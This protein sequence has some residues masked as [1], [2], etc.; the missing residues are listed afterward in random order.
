MLFRLDIKKG[1]ENYSCEPNPND[2]RINGYGRK[3]L[4]Q[5]RWAFEL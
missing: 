3:S 4:S 5:V 2:S 1:R